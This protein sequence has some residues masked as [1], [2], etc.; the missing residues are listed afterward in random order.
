[1]CE[2][3][4]ISVCVSADVMNVFMCVWILSRIVPESPHWPSGLEI[5]NVWDW[6]QM[7]TN[8]FHIF[9]QTRHFLFSFS[10]SSSSVILDKAVGKSSVF[11]VLLALILECLNSWTF[12]ANS[13][14]SL[15]KSVHLLCLSE[16]F[17][18]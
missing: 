2:Y 10:F 3:N 1:M 17:I 9:L 12:C 6:L 5:S 14:F 7:N 16:V 15:L 11:A 18:I 4:V 13:S 8:L